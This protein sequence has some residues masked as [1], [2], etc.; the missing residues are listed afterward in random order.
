MEWK[1]ALPLLR[2]H[3]AGVASTITAKGRVQSTIVSTAVLD[4]KV[5]VA[6]RPNTVKEKNIRRAGRA[7]ITVFRLDNRRYIT[8]EG[9]ASI[10]PWQDTPAH[11]KRLKDFYD[12]MGRA[13]G[14]D[15]AF[16]K[17]M[18]DE[19]RSLVLIAPEQLYGS[20]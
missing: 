12:S 11:I 17:Q 6:T 14:T 18:R 5:G 3:H 16:T 9:P 20:M 10:E 13:T 4:G 19:R 8:V 7:T 2:D 15:E 1:D